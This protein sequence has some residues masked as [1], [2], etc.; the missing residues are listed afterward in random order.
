MRL[1]QVKLFLLLS[2]SVFVL[3]IASCSNNVR[4]SNDHDS[5]ANLKWQR[6]TSDQITLSA[7]ADI[8]AFRKYLV[9]RGADWKALVTAGK[10]FMSTGHAS[11]AQVSPMWEGTWVSYHTHLEYS[12]TFP[13][14]CGGVGTGDLFHE[15]KFLSR[16]DGPGCFDDKGHV[17][18]RCLYTMGDRF[19][20][21]CD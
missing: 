14:L 16:H 17:L 2:F 9:S 7:S 21:V 1:T 5:L 19:F 18:N 20:V 3:L 10:V 12:D 13:L 6:L 15:W 11:S 4:T 8:A